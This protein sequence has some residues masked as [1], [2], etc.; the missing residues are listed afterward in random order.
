MT[1]RSVDGP[2]IDEM[3]EIMWEP[4]PEPEEPPYPSLIVESRIGVSNGG[5]IVISFTLYN[6]LQMS[7]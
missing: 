2:D 1:D 4:S 6:A 3:D 7:S 5:C